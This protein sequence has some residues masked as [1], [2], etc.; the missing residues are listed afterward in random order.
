MREFLQD[1][2][3]TG[4]DKLGEGRM[5]GEELLSL[6]LEA[7]TV[8]IAVPSDVDDNG[9]AKEPVKHL[10]ELGAM[11]QRNELQFVGRHLDFDTGV[12]AQGEPWTWIELFDLTCKAVA[13]PG[14]VF[15]IW[16]KLAKELQPWLRRLG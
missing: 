5:E 2:V 4:E 8:G 9:V 13:G 16:R 15:L 7:P 10:E 14:A 3:E 12:G 1:R 11:M 6:L